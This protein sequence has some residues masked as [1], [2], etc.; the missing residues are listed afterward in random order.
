M[1]TD[2]YKLLGI[3]PDADED[4]ITK[5][6][7]IRSLEKHPD[8]NNSPTANE[9]FIALKKA[10]DILLDPVKRLQ[11]DRQ[12]GYF[13]KPKNKDENVK[14]EFSDYQRKKA[15]NLVKEWST[16]Y[17]KAMRMRE[18]QRNFS[19]RMTKRRIFLLWFAFGVI[20]LFIVWIVYLFMNWHP[21][22]DLPQIK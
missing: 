18:E 13:G 19:I 7:R 9:E 2:C 8:R 11:H 12:F 5:A 21:L 15:E 4:A 14:Q 20:L 22:S 6:F 3:P 1:E 16:D 10:T 17:E